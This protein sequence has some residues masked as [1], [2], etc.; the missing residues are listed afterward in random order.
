MRLNHTLAALA[1]VI[2][3]SFGVGCVGGSKANKASAEA[4]KQYVLTAAP[5]DIP[6]KLEAVFDGKAKLLGYRISPEGDVKAGAEIRLT[7]YWECL[8]DIPDGWNLFTHVLNSNSQLIS[9]VDGAG[10]LRQWIDNRQILAPAVWEKG[11]IYVDEQV[12]SL[13][14]KLD[15]SEVTIV[16]GIWK[17]GDRLA[18]TSGSADKENRAI[19]AKLSTGIAAKPKPFTGI[20]V[21]HAKKLA[22][23]ETVKIDGKLDEDAW[24]KA[25][26]TGPLVDVSDGQLNRSFPVKASVKVLWDNT[27]MYVAFEV[28]SKT[29]NGDFP[30]N[31]K[32]PHLWEKDTIEIMI[33]PD[34]DN[35]D[36]YEIQINPQNLVFDTLYDDYNQP[37]DA[38]NG[39][40]G[41]MEWSSKVQSA[42]V[43]EGEMNKPDAGKSYTVEARVPWASF[44]K[45]PQSPPKVG[46]VWRMNFYA[47]KDNSG[48]AWSPILGEGNFHRASRFGKVVW[49][50][51]NEKP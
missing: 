16:T 35:K 49:A 47:M 28:S 6:N 33:D 26:T 42:V 13:P 12:F 44:A 24:T 21:L 2:I 46:D 3:A 1:I 29:I 19:V 9:N 37:Q 40:F 14:D 51:P 15:T 22:K 34:G 30:A 7:M 5:T 17:G 38:A 20:K 25:S 32:D 45:V 31:A 11:K 36:Y 23:G 41:H 43:V 27:Y 18:V 4:L 8:E 10:P 48:I 39:I 50:N